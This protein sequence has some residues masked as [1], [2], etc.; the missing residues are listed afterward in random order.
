MF[1]SRVDSI[2]LGYCNISGVA[3]EKRQHISSIHLPS[4]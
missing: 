1:V 2:G 3:S 4:D